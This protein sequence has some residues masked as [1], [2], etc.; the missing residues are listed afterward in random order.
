MAEC[1]E[2]IS[3]EGGSVLKIDVKKPGHFVEIRGG[4]YKSPNRFGIVQLGFGKSAETAAELGENLIAHVDTDLR[5]ISFFL[6]FRQC[7]RQ[8]LLARF[9]L[10]R[11]STRLNSS[12]V[13]TSYAVLC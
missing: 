1:S 11:K 7:F 4:P 2:Q 3:F 9:P 10:D 6:L 13:A 8:L 12:H 5:E